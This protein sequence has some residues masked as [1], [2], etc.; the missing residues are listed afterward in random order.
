MLKLYCLFLLVK[1]HKDEIPEKKKHK[2]LKLHKKIYQKQ[3][4][5]TLKI[6]EYNS[7]PRLQTSAACVILKKK[8]KV[9]H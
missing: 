9:L 7:I 5:L 6:I 8:F 4:V 2:Y 1:T 3:K